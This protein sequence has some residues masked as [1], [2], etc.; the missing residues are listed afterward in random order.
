MAVGADQAIDA[1]AALV[2]A[3]AGVP[4]EQLRS[5]TRLWHDLKL[6]GDDFVSLLEEL[7]RKHGVALRGQLGDYCPTEG[8][9][10]WAFWS[11]PFKRNKVYLELT[12]GELAIAARTGAY[13]G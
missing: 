7:N 2:A 5:T 3:H 11:W 12:V 8:D 10:N 13:V 6:A 4:V 1:V 9:L